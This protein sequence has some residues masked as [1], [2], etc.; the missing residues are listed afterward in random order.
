[1][2]RGI[3]KVELFDPL[4]GGAANGPDV[5]LVGFLAA[6]CSSTAWLI[7]A[8]YFGLPVSTTHSIV[9]SLVG[10]GMAYGGPAAV[11]WLNPTKTGLGRLKNSMVGVVASWV[12]SPL[13][14]ALF[15]VLIFLTVR[16]LVLRRANPFK[17]GL[18][19]LPFFYAV[20]VAIT[21][22][23]IIYKGSPQLRL[24]KKL[25]AVQAVGVALAGGGAM[26][27]L[28]W[29]FFIPQAKRFVDRWEAE[30][31]AAAGVTKGGR[32]VDSSEDMAA[33]MDVA[34]T[35]GEGGGMA[36]GLGKMGLRMNMDE[37]Q[38]ALQDDED[39]RAMHDRV[40]KFDPKAER[41]FTWLQI[42]TAAFDSFAHGPFGRGQL[43]GLRR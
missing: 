9:G 6:L 5:L 1:M 26:A 30:T 16:T 22:F 38:A 15:A 4:R 34:A 3:I 32:A 27:I 41:L 12:V 10:V 35:K 31:L 13:L 36:A 7:I 37:E 29:W 28:S 25:S 42:F 20:T 21:I 33:A 23:F 11:I 2:R 18:L 19:F 14:S 40:E 43:G 24:D 8:T 17:N 39:V